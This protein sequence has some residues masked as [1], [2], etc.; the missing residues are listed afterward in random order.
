MHQQS[1]PEFDADLA[2]DEIITLIVQINGKLRARLD[3]P[4]DVTQEAAR[5]AALADEN[6]QRHIAGKEIR[7]FIYVPGRLVNIVV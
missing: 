3:L 5:E 4:A 6:I 2:A 7:K 1:W